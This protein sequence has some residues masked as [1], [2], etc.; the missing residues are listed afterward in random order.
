MSRWRVSTPTQRKR[1]TNYSIDNLDRLNK[2]VV[3]LLEDANVAL[4][5]VP[6]TVEPENIETTRDTGIEELIETCLVSRNASNQTLIKR[7][8]SK[9][10]MNRHSQSQGIIYKTFY[11]AI[12]VPFNAINFFA[13]MWI[14]GYY[15][16]W[17]ASVRIFNKIA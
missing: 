10:R 4:K 9:I 13:I 7:N 6:P 3:D 17:N 1:K 5:H 2:I 12:N 8:T 11:Y 16:L 15:S 14:S